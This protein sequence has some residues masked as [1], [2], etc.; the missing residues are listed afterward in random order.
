MILALDFDG[1]IGD[2]TDDAF[3]GAFNTYLHFF[4][5]TALLSRIPVT[6]HNFELIKRRQG[7]LIRRFCGLRCYGGRTAEEL[8]VIFRI[9]DERKQIRGQEDFDAYLRLIL[10]EELDKYSTEYFQQRYMV[11]RKSPD[12][13]N[14]LTRPYKIVPD[15]AELMRGHHVIVVTNKDG[16]TADFWLNRFGLKFGKGAIFDKSYS[17]DKVRKLGF[18]SERLEVEMEDILF[19]DDQVSQ[20]IDVQKTGARCF[21]ATWGYNTKSQ[22]RIATDNG[23][24]LLSEK[25]FYQTM[26]GLLKK[27]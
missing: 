12:F 10:P 23:I 3:V 5:Q 18:V 26:S 11:M 25:G 4:P 17:Q 21:L 2:S 9:I 22:Q 1:V 20:L 8:I 24:T 15:V 19:V 27:S 13:Y 6:E 7:E 16:K 14:G